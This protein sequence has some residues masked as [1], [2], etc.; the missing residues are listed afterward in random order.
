MLLGIRVVST[1]TAQLLEIVGIIIM[2]DWKV[3]NFFHVCFDE[4]F[5]KIYPLILVLCVCLVRLQS[6]MSD[7]SLLYDIKWYKSMNSTRA[8]NLF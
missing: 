5:Y 7:H 3:S 2:L 1:V 4:D 8:L 6:R